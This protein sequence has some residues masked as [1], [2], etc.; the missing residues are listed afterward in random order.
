MTFLGELAQ[1]SFKDQQAMAFDNP[2]KAQPSRVTNSN[3][4]SRGR[5]NMKGIIPKQLVT[6]HWGPHNV[7]L[8][9]DNA[10]N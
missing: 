7:F 2:P 6:S 8:Q 10:M 3:V 5:E 1:F 9:L 4:D